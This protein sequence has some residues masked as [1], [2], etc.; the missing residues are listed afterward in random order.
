M[1][2]NPTWTWNV[3]KPALVATYFIWGMDNGVI[4]CWSCIVLSDSEDPS[5][6]WW[7]TGEF[8]S[9]VSWQEQGEAKRK[10]NPDCM[11]VLREEVLEAHRWLGPLRT[12]RNGEESREQLCTVLSILG[13]SSSPITPSFTSVPFLQ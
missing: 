11:Q 10:N 2:Q 1:V 5:C 3:P 12:V 6:L 13:G 9:G 8:Y 4:I 7:V